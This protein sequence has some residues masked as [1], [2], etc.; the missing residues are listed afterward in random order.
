MKSLRA[1]NILG[2]I[3]RTPANL[4][5]ENTMPGNGPHRLE[6]IGEEPL[7]FR[8]LAILF[9]VDILLGLALEFCG[10]YFLPRPSATLPPCRALTDGG[11][12][13]HAPAIVC[14]YAENWMWFAPILF[15]AVMLVMLVYHK[16]VRYVCRGHTRQN[17]S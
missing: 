3:V 15:A 9:A 11:T 16:Q 6:F 8:V 12:Q 5:N 2:E 4:S 14:S 10:K 7:I 17:R 13:Y 1:G